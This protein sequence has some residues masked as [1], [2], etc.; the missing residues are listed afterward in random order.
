MP[1]LIIAPARIFHMEHEWVYA[2]EVKK[3]FGDPQPGDVIT[4]RTS[5]TA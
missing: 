2:T 4:S 1:G 3:T 5:A